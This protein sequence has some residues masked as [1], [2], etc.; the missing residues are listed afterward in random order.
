LLSLPLAFGTTLET[1]PALVPYLKVPERSRAKA[2]AFPWPEGV[3]RIGLL[4]AGNPTFAQDRYRFRS[5]A[6]EVFKPLLA[7]DGPHW[8]SLQIGEA[9]TELESVPEAAAKIVDLSPLVEDMA[10]TA[11]QI[12]QLDLVITVDTAV[13]HL[14][15]ALGVPVWV[16]MPYTPD[17]RWLQERTD[18]PW[19]PLMRLFRQ[20]Q[21]GDWESVMEAMTANL[22]K[23][24]SENG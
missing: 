9:T 6:L 24:I 22:K 2:Q 5:V 4:W 21:P 18:T 10:D 19:Y 13:S 20:P 7:I 23:R 11:A 12:A 16:L 15:G 17:W 1:V 8:F 3:L 14:A